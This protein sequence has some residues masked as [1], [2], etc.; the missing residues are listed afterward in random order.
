MARLAYYTGVAW[1]GVYGAAYVIL[2]LWEF[3]AGTGSYCALFGFARG[4]WLLDSYW[5]GYAMMLPALPGLFLVIWARAYT[6]PPERGL[7]G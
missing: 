4:C 7:R 1:L 3:A 2:L 6:P 5:S